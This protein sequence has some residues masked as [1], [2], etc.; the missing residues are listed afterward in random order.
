[1]VA[2]WL[3]RWTRERGPATTMLSSSEP[4]KAAEGPGVC[5]M[6]VGETLCSRGLEL[7]RMPLLDSRK[8]F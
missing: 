2:T 5:V 7:G 4:E 3:S 1:M 6:A 8:P